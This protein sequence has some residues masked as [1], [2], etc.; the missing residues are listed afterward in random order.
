MSK[1]QNVSFIIPRMIYM[2]SFFFVLFLYLSA[3]KGIN[4]ALAQDQP[5]GGDRKVLKIKDVDFAFRWCPPNEN[6]MGFWMGETEVTQEQWQAV[7]GNNPSKW[8]GAKLPVETVNW[9]DCQDF[10]KKLNEILTRNGS[11]SFKCSIPTESQW[12]YAYR[13]NSKTRFY[14]GDDEEQLRYYAW[15]GRSSGKQTHQVGQLK[16]KARKT[17]R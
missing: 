4:N 17:G 11:S 10:C 16:P 8:K 5:K 12:G 7:N 14:F 6:Q 9:N 15:Y 1:E 3:I 13:A 2:S